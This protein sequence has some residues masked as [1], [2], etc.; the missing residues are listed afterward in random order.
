MRH[1]FGSKV[2]SFGDPRE[3]RFLDQ[4][5]VVRSVRQVFGSRS[6]G[7]PV[8]HVTSKRSVGTLRETGF[9]IRS[10]GTL[11]QTGNVFWTERPVGTQRSV[12]QE[13]SWGPPFYAPT[14]QARGKSSR[15]SASRPCRPKAGQGLVISTVGALEMAPPRDNH[16]IPPSIH[17]SHL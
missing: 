11:R 3:T 13:V 17:P 1:V 2:R 12:G 8:R 15:V 16:P 10:V 4:R 5:S 14:E 6:V 7:T 9:W